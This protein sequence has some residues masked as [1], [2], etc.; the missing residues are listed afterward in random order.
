MKKMI[1]K[2]KRP[3]VFVPMSIDCF[4][5]GHL[6]ILL[7]AK[8]LG[9][10]VVGLMTDKGILSYK[11]KLPLIK[12]NDRKK[13]L[14]HLNCV[15]WII[16]LNGI[17]FDKIAEKYEFD[18]V[19]HGSDWKFGVQAKERKKLVSKMQKWGGKVID[20]PYTANISSTIIKKY[21][22]NL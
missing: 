2:L 11:K 5:H 22:K 20:V 6:N 18:Y 3:Y 21:Y 8:K 17:F 14:T 7:R 4:H 16:S 12:Y 9:N 13:I 10:V 1:K 19:V 15:D